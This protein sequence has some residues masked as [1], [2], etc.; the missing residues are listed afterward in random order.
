MCK[1]V[2]PVLIVIWIARHVLALFETLAIVCSLKESVPRSFRAQKKLNKMFSIVHDHLLVTRGRH[3][4]LNCS[5]VKKIAF[6]WGLSVN[7][8]LQ[9]VGGWKPI[10]MQEII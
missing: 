8:S 2:R 10:A 9:H 1:H 4:R 5:G 3:L 7:I 6:V